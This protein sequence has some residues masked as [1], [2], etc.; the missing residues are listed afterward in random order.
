MSLLSRQ[1]DITYG[2]GGKGG[3]PVTTLTPTD[4]NAA[5]S[6]GVGSGG[7][8]CDD[9]CESAEGMKLIPMKATEE[10]IGGG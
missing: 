2:F 3:C 10:V 4:S 5:D 1:P 9:I 8:R 6:H 7:D